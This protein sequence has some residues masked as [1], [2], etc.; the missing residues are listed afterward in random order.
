[1]PTPG[2]TIIPD[3]QPNAIPLSQIQ[4]QGPFSAQLTQPAFQAPEVRETGYGGP[5]HALLAFANSFLQGASHGRLRAFQQSEV[6]KKEHENNFDA[7][8]QH[9]MD[10]PLYTQ[11]FKEDVAK[12]ALATKSS[13]G[14][15][16][17]GGGKGGKNEHPM[18]GL[19]RGVLN[20]VIGPSENVKHVDIG[21]EHVS[22]LLTQAR[23]PRN[24]FNL[25]DTITDTQQKLNDI[26]NKTKLQAAATNATVLKGGGAP[27][28]INQADI[29]NHPETADAFRTL[30]RQGIEPTALPAIQQAL[31]AVPPK[32]SPTQLADIEEKKAYAARARD[33]G[34]RNQGQSHQAL[35]WTWMDADGNRQTGAVIKAPNGALLDPISQEPL[36]ADDP[37]AKGSLLTPGM[38]PTYR[39]GF[40]IIKVDDGH[41]GSVFQEVPE[42]TIT[43]KGTPPPP[44]GA[45]QSGTPPAGSVQ[46]PSQAPGQPGVIQVAAKNNNPGNL[47]FKNQPG[48]VLAPDGRFAQFSTPEAGFQALISN[49]TANQSGNMTLADYITKYAPPSVDGNNTKQYIDNASKAL[50][51]IPGT[52]MSQID[53]TKL[54]AFQAKQESSTTVSP[55][56]TPKTAAPP[57]AASAASGRILGNVPKTPAELKKEAADKNVY[58][59]MTPEEAAA[60]RVERAGAPTLD[61]D[62]WSYLLNEKLLERGLG[63]SMSPRLI[64][65]KHAADTIMQDLGMDAGEVMARRAELKSDLPALTK[66]TSQ[67]NLIKTFENTLLA[68]ANVAKQLSKD[69]PRYDI[70]FANRVLGAFKTGKGDSE[71]LNLAGQLHTVAVEWA[72]VLA[73]TT[74]A[75]AP[76]KSEID[77]ANEK[78]GKAISDGQLDS[79]IDNVIKPDAANRTASFKTQQQELIGKIRGTTGPKTPNPSGKVSV[80]VPGGGTM[81]LDP[82]KVQ[83]FKAAHPGAQ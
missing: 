14:L 74:G 29:L 24:Q 72:K 68:N 27:I 66:L 21:P 12:Q 10:S 17:L 18:V 51:V 16:A 45:S 62:A 79:F 13:A 8:V 40:K 41:G 63:E 6:D 65:I 76:P 28:E 15:A 59:A 77:A 37:R 7:T 20:S 2:A 23:D 39:Q 43:G 55:A 64:K 80:T 22:D 4:T 48:A 9:I 5:G 25:G 26:I 52:P 73:G 35:S 44:V 69:Y 81:L 19:A 75:A 1:M 47:E 49:V 78:I 32:L 31:S 57:V 56:A 61:V 67:G 11:D 83:A 3:T 53:P 50:G 30:R 70:Q 46:I 42:T 34:L 33:I 71:A 54:A 38:L 60:V 36:T 82:D 58:R